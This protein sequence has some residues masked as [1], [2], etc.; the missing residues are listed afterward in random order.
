MFWLKHKHP[1]PNTNTQ[2]FSFIHTPILL[3]LPFSTTQH[4]LWHQNNKKNFQTF[5]T[6]NKEIGEVKLVVVENNMTLIGVLPLGSIPIQFN[7]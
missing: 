6:N 7:S 3:K 5:H 1:I 4:H 2:A